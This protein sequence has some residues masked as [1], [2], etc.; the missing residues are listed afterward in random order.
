MRFHIY[1]RTITCNVHIICSL[2]TY[3]FKCMHISVLQFMWTICSSVCNVREVFKKSCYPC[4][5]ITERHN[6]IKLCI[7]FHQ[8]SIP[9]QQN[10]F[11]DDVSIAHTRRDTLSWV[12]GVDTG[13]QQP[14]Y[15]VYSDIRGPTA[16]NQSKKTE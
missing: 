15:H 16:Y 1:V 7:T 3:A 4:E 5:I 13:I 11:S 8:H 10:T 14:P 12:Y 9:S 2:P 6:S